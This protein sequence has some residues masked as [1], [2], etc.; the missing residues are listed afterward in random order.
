MVL[1]CQIVSAL[2]M[3]KGRAYRIDSL[4]FFSTNIGITVHVRGAKKIIPRALADS[5]RDCPPRPGRRAA[6]RAVRLPSGTFRKQQ[7]R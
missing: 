4:A 6:G 7:K 1:I 3:K 2:Q 5:P